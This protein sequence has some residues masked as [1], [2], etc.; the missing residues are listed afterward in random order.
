MHQKFDANERNF[1][2][3]DYGVRGVLTKFNSHA[4]S[5]IAL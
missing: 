2:I 4:I 3:L 1:K 5:S